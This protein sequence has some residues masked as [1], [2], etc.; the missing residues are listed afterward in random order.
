MRDKT[1]DALCISQTPVQYNISNH[2]LVGCGSGTWG[3]ALKVPTGSKCSAGI[4]ATYSVVSVDVD[5]NS[6]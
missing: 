6:L 2:I 1:K 4:D 5:A 3:V